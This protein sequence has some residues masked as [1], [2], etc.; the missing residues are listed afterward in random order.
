MSL[1]EQLNTDLK[2]AMKSKDSQRVTLL[3][4]V[5]AAFKEAEQHKRE[6]LTKQAAKKH[7]VAKPTQRGSSDEDKAA[8]EADVA[9]YAKA[10]DAALAAEKV[11]EK[12]ALD[13]AEMLASIQKLIKMRQDSIADAQKANRD[14]IAQAEEKELTQLQA[15]LPKQLSREEIEEEARAI[16]AQVGATGPRDM[17]KV[18][19]PL[20]GK[21]KGHADGKLISEVVKTL[22]AG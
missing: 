18:M 9:A 22:L 16:I 20:T 10:L 1:K 14:D 15:Y 2:E 19:G 13:E 3:R 12:V 17:G 8:Y 4:G 7:N 6:D 21:L 11:N 5:M